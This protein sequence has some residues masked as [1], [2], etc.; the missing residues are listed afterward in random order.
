MPQTNEPDSQGHRVQLPAACDSLSLRCS[1]HSQLLKTKTAGWDWLV[2]RASIT[3]PCME[4]R[5]LRYFV[6]VAEEG[7]I[8]RAAKRIFLTQP[9]LSRQIKALEEE[10][11]HCLLERQAHSVRLTTVGKAFL[12]E[13]QGLLKHATE[14]LEHAKQAHPTVH[15]RVGYAPSLAS[16]FLSEVLERF[17]QIHPSARVELLDLSSQEML[18]QLEAETLDVAVLPGDRLPTH[19]IDWVPLWRTP[20]QLAVSRKH[21]LAKR[22]KVTPE[23]IASEPLLMYCR[24]DYPEYWD[25]VQEWLRPHRKQLRIKGEYD[26]VESLMAGVGS[27]SGVALVAGR[28][29]GRIPQRVQLKTISNSPEPLCIAAALRKPSASSPALAVFIEEL[30]KVARQ[31]NSHLSPLR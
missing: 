19:R 21:P 8:S 6:A 25:F 4:L 13:A 1:P 11:G 10:I 20:W 12:P 30:K 7:S 9:A 3:V 23:E 16:D 28:C 18:V 15:I 2:Q 29:T 26:G 17:V 5:Q 22:T 27:G 24:K 31:Q 14:V